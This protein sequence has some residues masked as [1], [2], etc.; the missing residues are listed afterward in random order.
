MTAWQGARGDERTTLGHR[1][2]VG[3][4]GV[5]VGMVGR[6]VIVAVDGIGVCV[7]V[8]VNVGVEV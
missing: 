8:S 5:N 6:G 3:V 7:S 4:G 2:A 1:P